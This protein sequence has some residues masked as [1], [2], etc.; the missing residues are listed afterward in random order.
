MSPPEIVP[1][2]SP[3]RY[4]SLSLNAWGT[5]HST[6]G[7]GRGKALEIPRFPIEILIIPIIPRGIP[8]IPEGIPITPIIPGKNLK[9]FV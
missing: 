5:D 9:E 8:I 2:S 7:K 6:G 3:N 1:C 4:L